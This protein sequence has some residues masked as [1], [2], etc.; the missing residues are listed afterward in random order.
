[1]SRILRHK[2]PLRAYFK[3]ANAQTATYFTSV[4]SRIHI[5]LFVH[6]LY[7]VFLLTRARRATSM[8]RNLLSFSL[9]LY[10][11]YIY[12]LLWYARARAFNVGR[13]G[14]RNVLRARPADAPCGGEYRL[15][16]GQSRSGVG[17]RARVPGG[18]GAECKREREREVLGDYY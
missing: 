12:R 18:I 15:F 11:L 16:A 3:P 7:T 9:S 5:P 17:A 2:S 6:L 1:M 4:I 8:M 14:C 10:V 13:G